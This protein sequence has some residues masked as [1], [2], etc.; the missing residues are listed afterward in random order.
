[1]YIKS[2][3]ILIISF[4]IFSGSVDTLNDISPVSTLKSSYIG[5]LKPKLHKKDITDKLIGYKAI[6]D[7]QKLNKLFEPPTIYSIHQHLPSLE[8]SDKEIEQLIAI[9]K[10]QERKVKVIIDKKITDSFSK[11]SDESIL[12]KGF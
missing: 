3:S 11:I 8:M 9:D 5:C 7:L 2:P 12:V 6:S 10:N 1:V 4:C